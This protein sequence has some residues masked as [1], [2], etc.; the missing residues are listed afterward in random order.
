M[1]RRWLAK[2][3]LAALERRPDVTVTVRSVFL[4]GLLAGGAPSDW[5]TCRGRPARPAIEALVS[6]L[7]RTNRADLCV[8]YA[9][10][11]G[12]GDVG[13]PGGGDARAGSAERGAGRNPPLTADGLALVGERLPA[14]SAGLVD[15]ST[16]RKS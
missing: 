14:G 1:D 9:L 7:G 13:R 5:R 15:P 6:E 10:G 4:Q 8:A 12:F 11:H 2:P 3:V 16:W